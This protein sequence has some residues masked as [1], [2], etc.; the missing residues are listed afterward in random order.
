MPALPVGSG[1]RVFSGDE[2]RPPRR[3]KTSPKRPDNKL[4]EVTLISLLG[5]PASWPPLACFGLAGRSV[6]FTREAFRR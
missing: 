2:A 3:G 6:E 4:H 5:P 1:I